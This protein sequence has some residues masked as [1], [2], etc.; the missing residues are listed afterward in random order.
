MFPDILSIKTHLASS[1]NYQFNRIYCQYKA[2]GRATS[3]YNISYNN[4]HSL[5]KFFNGF[6][7]ETKRGRRE[8]EK[9]VG[10]ILHPKVNL[11]LSIK[12][13]C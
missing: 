7:I 4:Y 1:Y 3:F 11:A 9:E 5:K 12:K 2:R 8:R 13:I 6:W 10:E